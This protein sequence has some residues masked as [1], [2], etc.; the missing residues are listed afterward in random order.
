MSIFQA[1]GFFHFVHRA[2]LVEI[3]HDALIDYQVFIAITRLGEVVNQPPQLHEIGVAL[4]LDLVRE[5]PEL[6]RA[7]HIIDYFNI[8]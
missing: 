7:D 3:H 8:Y 1:V 2:I 5:K 4:H 6:A